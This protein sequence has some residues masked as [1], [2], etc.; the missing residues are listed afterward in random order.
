MS[1]SMRERVKDL[2]GIDL[3]SNDENLNPLLAI[4][5]AETIIVEPPGTKSARRRIPAID[6]TVGGYTL[7]VKRHNHRKANSQMWWLGPD[8]AHATSR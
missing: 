7:V 5:T 6:N 2:F 1:D 8:L 4:P 3:K